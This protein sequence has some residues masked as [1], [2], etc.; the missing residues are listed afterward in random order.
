M[1]SYELIK[2]IYERNMHKANIFLSQKQFSFFVSLQV[3]EG[4]FNTC[5]NHGQ[6]KH[7]VCY[8]DQNGNWLDSLTLEESIKLDQT[9][10]KKVELVPP[11]HY[12]R[13]NG[14]NL[15]KIFISPMVV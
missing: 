13:K 4:N 12:I 10:I 2:S 6:L 15:Y 1:K 3:S 11:P 14:F 9:K 8:I 5:P 7:H